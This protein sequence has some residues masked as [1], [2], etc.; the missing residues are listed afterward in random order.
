ML[1]LDLLLLNNDKR[2]Q[3]MCYRLAQREF[4][5]AIPML[6]ESWDGGRDIF[7]FGQDGEPDII[8][9]CK[10]VSRIDNN[11][12]KAIEASLK[13]LRVNRLKSDG[14][15]WILCMPKDPTA[16]FFEWL[17]D[18]TRQNGLLLAIWGRS[19]LLEKLESHPDLVETFFF[20]VF[21]ELQKHFRTDALELIKLR[22][23][24][25]SQWHQSDPDVLQFMRSGNVESPDLA[26]DIIVR[27]RGNIDTA[28][29][30]IAAELA[31]VHPKLHG[32]PGEGLLLPQISYRLSIKGGEP[33]RHAVGCEPPLEVPRGALARFKLCLTDTGYAWS[34]TV[35]IALEYGIGKALPLPTLELFT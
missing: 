24:P 31:H 23:D 26:L 3:N 34:G 9:Q 11:L 22:L 8:W 35:K 1:D 19:A 25:Q 13:K 4:P 10:F 16:P 21:A 28:L 27:N 18:V 33:G 29:M 15:R 2:F 14:A 7:N 17:T 20:P 6:F 32:V 30:K 12:K 5:S